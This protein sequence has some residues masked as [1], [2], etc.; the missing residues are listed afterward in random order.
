MGFESANTS[1]TG[2]VTL[3]A[4]SLSLDTAAAIN[5]FQNATLN[6]TGGSFTF[7]SGSTALTLGGL[8]GVSG[9]TLGPIGANLALSVGGNNQST[10]YAGTLA[11]SGSYALGLTK[12]A[13]AR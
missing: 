7:L 4:G 9:V 10:V 5:A 8:S 3:S 11:N 13:P 2:T 1:I 12:T 6:Y